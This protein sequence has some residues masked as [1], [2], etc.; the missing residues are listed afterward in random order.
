MRAAGRY[1]ISKVKIQSII[2]VQ[3]IEQR[4]HWSLIMVL[5]TVQEL[6]F[7]EKVYLV[8]YAQKVQRDTFSSCH[9]WR[10]V[11]QPSYLNHLG[12][13]LISEH[14]CKAW[15]TTAP[16]YLIVKSILRS[17]YTLPWQSLIYAISQE[18][19][20]SFF[21]GLYLWCLYKPIVWH[22]LKRQGT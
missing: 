1:H 18:Y 22:H 16:C 15:A 11:S 4:F 13:Y 19:I 2:T 20:N 21:C 17:F 7:L 12:R 5:P 9:L 6:G 10:S 3:G 14:P 8:S